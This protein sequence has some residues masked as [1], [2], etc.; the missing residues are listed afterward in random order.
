MEVAE[1]LPKKIG[2]KSRQTFD[3][4]HAQSWSPVLRHPLVVGA[5]LAILSG[6]LASLVLPAVTRVWQDRPDELAL[7]QV[8]VERISQRATA[9]IARGESLASSGV[10]SVDASE[11]QQNWEVDAAGISS[12]LSTYFRDSPAATQWPHFEDAVSEFL[13]Y[14]AAVDA[15]AQPVRARLN[16]LGEIFRHTNFTDPVAERLR[17]GFVKLPT[18]FGQDAVVELLAAWKD[19]LQIDVL[20]SNASGFSHGF[21]F[22]H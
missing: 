9:T 10:A 12:Q 16:K 13:F 3:R 19:K 4:S 11:A 17:L 8:V 6:V 22:L 7:K 1:K 15:G 20:D 2:A 18:A 5:V 21:W 14:G